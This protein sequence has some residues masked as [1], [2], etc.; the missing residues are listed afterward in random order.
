[1]KKTVFLLFI[2]ALAFAQA[3]LIYV[4]LQ[5]ETNKLFTDL[6]SSFGVAQS[7][8]SQFVFRTVQ[9]WTVLPTT[10]LALGITSIIKPS[11]YLAF[12]AISVSLAGTIA[13]YW[14]VYAPV[15]FINI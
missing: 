12:I 15:L 2:A 7:S 10:C 11:T 13:L 9:W 1:M 8:Y 6:W 3:Y 5:P 4:L 14:A